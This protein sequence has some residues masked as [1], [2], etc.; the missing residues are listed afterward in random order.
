MTVL[1]IY[2]GV[3]SGLLCIIGICCLF[4]AVDGGPIYLVAAGVLLHSRV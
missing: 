2:K 1:E 4:A 3:G